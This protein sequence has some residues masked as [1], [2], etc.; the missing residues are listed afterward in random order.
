MKI[1]AVAVVV[2]LGVAFCAGHPLRNDGQARL[3]QQQQQ[4]QVQRQ[5][6]GL[7]NQEPCTSFF[8]DEKICM[9]VEGVTR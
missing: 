3:Q 9:V 1:F 2:L 4:Q 8:G 6:T 7:A 5:D